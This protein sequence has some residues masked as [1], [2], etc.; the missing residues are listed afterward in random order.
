MFT[1]LQRTPDS[2][3]GTGLVSNRKVPAASQ[4]PAAVLVAVGDHSLN[5]VA[6]SAVNANQRC[7]HHPKVRAWSPGH[8][9]ASCYSRGLP[10]CR[11]LPLPFGRQTSGG[12][13]PLQQN[14]LSPSPA[15]YCIFVCLF[16][17]LPPPAR[18]NSH[19]SAIHYAA[20]LKPSFLFSRD[21]MTKC[22]AVQCCTLTPVSTFKS[23]GS[24]DFLKYIW[25]HWKKHPYTWHSVVIYDGE[26]FTCVRV[27]QVSVFG[28][29]D[30][31]HAKSRL[32]NRTCFQDVT[33]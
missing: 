18:Y 6:F 9:P 30:I 3:E 25:K 32:W 10:P 33:G 22:S 20:A 23:R 11:H 13:L 27:S 15:C 16:F 28:T 1:C 24:N 8:E 19:S 14:A 7:G 26:P 12:S 31:T 29:I 17:N 4:A 21:T 5:K 2:P